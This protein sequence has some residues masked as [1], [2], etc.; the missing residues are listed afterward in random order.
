MSRRDDEVVLLIDCREGRRG[1]IRMQLETNEFCELFGLDRKTLDAWCD[2]GLPVAGSQE[3]RQQLDLCECISWLVSCRLE[4]ERSQREPLSPGS[5]NNI[6]DIAFERARLERLQAER[7]ELALQRERMELVPAWCLE[8]LLQMV[9]SVFVCLVDTWPD[10]IQQQLPH[11]SRQDIEAI[12]D[13]MISGRNQLARTPPTAQEI[14][15]VL[16][17]M[18]AGKH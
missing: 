16:V 3:D 1:S 5:N 10:E 7:E 15:Q 9:T 17:S 13:I 6:V 4:Q 14:E 12:R 18:L 2:A 11:L 8:R